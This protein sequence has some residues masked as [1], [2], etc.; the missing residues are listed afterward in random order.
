MA[1][2]ESKPLDLTVLG[3]N[4]GTSMVSLYEH[5]GTPPLANIAHQFLLLNSITT[6]GFG[7]PCPESCFKTNTLT[8]KVSSKFA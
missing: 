7:I 2:Q 4:S 8:V 1:L 3:L 6:H 5:Q